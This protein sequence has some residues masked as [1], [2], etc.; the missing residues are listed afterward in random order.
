MKSVKEMIEESVQDINEGNQEECERLVRRLVNS[1]IEN[2]NKIST[3][4]KEIEEA[5]KKLEELKAPEAV[6]IEV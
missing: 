6:S 5:K 4:Q 1:I 3:A 2:K